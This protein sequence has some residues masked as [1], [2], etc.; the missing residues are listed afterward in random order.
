VLERIGP[1][2]TDR[3]LQWILAEKPLHHAR[4]AEHAPGRK[5]LVRGRPDSRA[6]VLTRS[7]LLL[8]TRGAKDRQRLHVRVGPLGRIRCPHESQGQSSGIGPRSFSL[9][10]ECR[11]YSSGISSRTPEARRRELSTPTSSA[12]TLSRRTPPKLNAE[13]SRRESREGISQR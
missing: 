10:L 9:M 4:L 11:A 12:A 6:A 8:K 5:V 7:Q 1:F 3:V 2:R 13:A